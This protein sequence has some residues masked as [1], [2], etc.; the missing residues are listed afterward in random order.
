MIIKKLAKTGVRISILFTAVI[1]LLLAGVGIFASEYMN[2]LWG[3]GYL[4]IFSGGIG[5]IL[6]GVFFF[7]SFV[8]WIY[9]FKINRSNT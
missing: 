1:L 8:S 4:M 2:D 3:M 5:L 6:L 7:A 9:D